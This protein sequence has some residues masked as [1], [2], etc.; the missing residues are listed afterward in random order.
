M[1]YARGTVVV[2][3]GL[4]RKVGYPPQSKQVGADLRVGDA[5]EFLLGLEVMASALAGTGEHGTERIG[6]FARQNQPSN[7]V[8]QGGHDRHLASVP[9]S[10]E[11]AGDGGGAV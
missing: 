11:H 6:H 4:N 7:I 5:K 10:G 3:D 8:K 2:R 9:V 1:R